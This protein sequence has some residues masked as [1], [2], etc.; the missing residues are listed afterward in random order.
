MAKVT[1]LLKWGLIGLAAYKAVSYVTN[2]I[3]TAKAL[4]A[5]VTGISLNG[6]TFPFLNV[7]LQV[8]VTNPTNNPANA[9]SLSGTLS[10][11]TVENFGTFNV[12]LN[13]SSEIVIPANDFALINV[14][15]KINVV[16]AAASL[17][18]N[19]ASVNIAGTI[20]VDGIP[21]PFDN[22]LSFGD[23]GIGAIEKE[24]TVYYKNTNGRTYAEPVTANSKKEAAEKLK[25]RRRASSTFHKVVLVSIK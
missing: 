12:Q 24:Y 23:S 2:K 15:A 20:V 7:I 13:T 19:G 17:I 3:T 25:Q 18:K 16:A 5:S 22:N 21:L 9:S 4:T 11:K 10:S 1:S 8:K 6:F 14:D